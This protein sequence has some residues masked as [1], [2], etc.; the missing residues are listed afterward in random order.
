MTVTVQ[1][2]WDRQLDLAALVLDAA[3]LRILRTTSTLHSTTHKTAPRVLVTSGA[4][5]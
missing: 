1:R 3:T 2:A 4:S 5:H